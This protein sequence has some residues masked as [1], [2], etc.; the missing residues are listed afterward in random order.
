MGSNLS[1][2]KI[3]M[4]CIQENTFENDICQ[5]ATILSQTHFY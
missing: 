4:M 2:I 1:E 3:K 5:M